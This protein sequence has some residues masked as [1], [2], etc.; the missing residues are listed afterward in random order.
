MPMSKSDAYQQALQG[1]MRDFLTSVDDPEH[2]LRVS[3]ED[4]IASLEIALRASADARAH[5]PW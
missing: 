5:R 4:G 2:A 3:L 1:L